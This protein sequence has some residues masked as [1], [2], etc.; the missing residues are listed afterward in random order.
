[1]KSVSFQASGTCTKAI[2]FDIDDEQRIHNVT[3]EGGCPGNT[4]GIA[5]LIEGMKAQ[6]VVARLKGLRC[7]GKP[8]S[9]P[10]QLA[11]ALEQELAAVARQRVYHGVERPR[12]TPGNISSLRPDEVFVFGSNLAGMHGGGAA[13][14]AY[15]HFG[16]VWGQGVGLQ[17]QSYAIPTM[18]GGVEEIK[19]YVDDFVAFA[20][21]HPELFFFVTRIGCGI[22]G[23]TDAQMAPLFA[24][25]LHAPNVCLPASF[26]AVLTGDAS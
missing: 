18:H 25:A 14:A 17:G 15:T 9:C 12:F 11:V 20:V 24:G 26:V 1:M 4:L 21:A 5:S 7:G 16:A 8:T 10:D 3:F 23:F 19:P 13:R 22:A 2:R 6:D